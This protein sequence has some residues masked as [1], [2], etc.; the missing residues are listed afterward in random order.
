MDVRSAI[1]SRRS[2]RDFKD[3]PVPPEILRR[4]LACAV[5]APSGGNLQPWHFHVVSG[6]SMTALKTLMRQ[7]LTET[8]TGET[9]EYD[10]YP[11]NLPAPYR[12]RRYQIGEQLYG[13]LNIPREDKLGRALWFAKNFEFFGAPLGLFCSID[14]L[15]GPPQWSDLGMV[16]QNV[17]LLLRAEGLDSC[18]Q[19]CWAVFPQTIGTFLQLPEHRMLFA[20]MAIGYANAENPINQLQTPRAPLD[21]VCTFL[22]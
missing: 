19:E 5:R 6:A 18:P 7:R 1:E 13:Q 21:E 15:M 12:D 10:I 20:G 14:R 8:P 17:M 16:L 3:T 9:P 11:R 2:V 22:D 4:I